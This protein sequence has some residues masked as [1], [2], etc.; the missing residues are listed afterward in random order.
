M[1]SYGANCAAS[2]LAKRG[3]KPVSS[4]AAMVADRG[5]WLSFS[6]RGGYAALRSSSGGR[7]GPQPGWQQPHGVLHTL[8]PADVQ[9]LQGREGG[10]SLAQLSVE[11]YSG[12][13]CTAATFL[14]S[15]LLLL[16]SPVPPTSRY[17]DLLLEGCRQHALDDDYTA[18][19]EGLEV[20]PAGGARDACYDACPADSLAK[21]LAASAVAAATL[22]SLR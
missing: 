20:A 6:H 14:S 22:V 8:T 12:R 19:L 17:R 9:R 4:E 3:V 21:L 10:Y 11:T 16:S 13:A 5:T 18:W 15:P 2:V 7:P 1:F